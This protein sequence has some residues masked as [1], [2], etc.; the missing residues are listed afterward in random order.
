MKTKGKVL[1]SSIASIA[2]C[3]SI[4]FGGTYALF[5]S[6]SKVNIAVTSGKVEVVASVNA[7]SLKTYSMD[8]EQADGSFENGGT[9]TLVDNQLTLSLMSPGDKATFTID[10]KNKST[11]TVQYKLTWTVE[12]D[13]ADG[14][15]IL[16]NDNELADVNWTELA[17]GADVDSFAVSV[18]LPATAGKEYQ[19]KSAQIS[20][21]VEA[22]QANGIKM[23]STE[24]ELKDAFAKGGNIALKND[25]LGIETLEIPENKVVTL[26]L[27]GYALS[28]TKGV[29]IPEDSIFTLKNT[30]T[31]LTVSGAGT[32]ILENANIQATTDYALALA[33]EYAGKIVL[34]GDNTLIGATEGDGIY[35]PA[36]AKLD[37]SGSGSLVAKGNGGVED[38]ATKIG[39]NGI[40]GEGEIYIHDLASLV[41]EGY[42][43]AGFGI[44][45]ET[46]SITINKTE[47]KYVKGG[48]VQPN[49]INDTKYGKSEPEGGAAIG[50][51][52]DGAVIAL[53]SVTI[54]KAEGGSKSAGIGARYWT[55][56]T[57]N[58]TDSVIKEVYGG[59]ASAGI[60]GSRIKK[61]N[62][63]EQDV[64]INIKNS[65]IT[66]YGGEYGAGIGGG[67]DT[68]C[69]TPELSPT[70]TIN[71]TGDSVITA[72]GG[73]YAA[74]IGTGYHAGG[75]DG[76]IEST[77][78]VNAT[79]GEKF[80]KDTYTQAQDVGFGVIDPARDGLNNECTITY[81]GEEIGVP[82]VSSN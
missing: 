78:T 24:A 53:D 35:V 10:V 56:V 48:F 51:M 26:D 64:T 60:G 23:V 82:A 11:I 1:L 7:E 46:T 74:G 75:L 36:T 15:E 22:V 66:A 47:I 34:Q 4:A 52:K 67:Y 42:G 21:M 39:G 9:A 55:S 40:G 33:N 77:V 19:E 17:V 18:E 8:V 70:I 3:S 76:T 63:A 73:R 65:V 44:G 5:T 6:E 13:L 68:H 50:S 31:P 38:K 57:I 30:N 58:I 49:L 32:F 72:K 41:A 29:S 80:Y 81:N 27:N 62:S 61:E 79:S 20:F 69:H 71:I 59:N 16:A 45:G 14:L 28:D 54:E 43:Q 12:G 2:L 37:L 25:I